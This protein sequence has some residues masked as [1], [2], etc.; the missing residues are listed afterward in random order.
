MPESQE[1][2]EATSRLR[3]VV[4]ERGNRR[5]HCRIEGEQIWCGACERTPL[6]AFGFCPDC[7]AV[8]AQVLEEPRGEESMS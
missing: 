7:G 3:T 5:Y 2:A 4:V 1:R 6:H 8:I